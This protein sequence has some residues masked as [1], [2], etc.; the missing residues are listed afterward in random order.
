[1]AS[2]TDKK[3]RR[4]FSD[5]ESENETLSLETSSQ[6][7]KKRK[8]FSSSDEDE[9]I[10]VTTK[11]T[12]IRTNFHHPDFSESDTEDETHPQVS[13]KTRKDFSSSEDD[14]KVETAPKNVHVRTISHRP[15]FSESGSEDETND[16]FASVNIKT[17]VKKRKDFSD[18]E[19]E[20]PAVLVQSKVA[21]VKPSKQRRDFSDSED[22]DEKT[23]KGTSRMMSGANRPPVRTGHWS[24][25]L[26]DSMNNPDLQIYKDDRIV[27]IKDK[28]PKAK[29]HYLV[30]PRISIPSLK[31]LKSEHLELLKD[32]HKKGREITEKHKSSGLDF[33][34]GYHCVPSM[35]HLHMHVIS[36][37]FNSPCLKTKKHWNSFTTQYFVGSKDIIEQL[38]T[39]GRVN[40]PAAGRHAELLKTPLRCHVCRQAQTNMPKLKQHILQHIKSK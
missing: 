5:S 39:T 36:Q 25:G 27:V 26:L 29:Y 16:K 24:M 18:S 13:A 14:D 17:E 31:S 23:K 4:D 1:M 7:S 37:D 9:A 35:S 6:P 20:Q 12:N 19:E 32:I 33:R 28:Y 8:D 11:S 2:K 22:E 40:P 34:L 15:D 30:L 38:E 21:S 3:K 10:G